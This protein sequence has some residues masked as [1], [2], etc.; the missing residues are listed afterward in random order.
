MVPK[1][2]NQF[3]NGASPPSD[4]EFA[5]AVGAALR[6]ELG[7]SRRA[8]KTVMAWAHVSDRTARGWLQGLHS[9][10]GCHLLAL[11][12]HSQRVMGLF[13]SLAG[14]DRLRVSLGL[15]SL[16]A[17]LEQMLAIIQRLRGAT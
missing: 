15:A 14:Q 9:P 13:L 1:T 10:G 8:T 17:E 3:P 7:A 6:G 12:A 16:E 5:H 2:G 4:V 11:A